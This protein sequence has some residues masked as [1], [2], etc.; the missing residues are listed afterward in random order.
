MC[1]MSIAINTKNICI[2]FKKCYMFYVGER[3]F[4][5]LKT[6]NSTI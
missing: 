2:Y 5:Y 3:Q 6:T 4:W 1:S